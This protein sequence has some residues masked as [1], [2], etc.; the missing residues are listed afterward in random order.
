VRHR[1]LL[2]LGSLFVL[3]ASF[4]LATS[5]IDAQARPDRVDATSLM[6]AMPTAGAEAARLDAIM[7]G[8]G[9]PAVARAAAPIAP[10]AAAQRN[11]PEAQPLADYAFYPP[12]GA[13][14]DRPLRLLV[15]LHGMGGNGPEM[16]AALLP[17]A[18]AQGW[19]V[20]APTM[21]YRDFRDPELVRRD[22]ELLPR[23]KATLDA[24]PARTGLAFEPRV[25]LFGFSR[26][27]Q[28]SIR[29]SLMYPDA[30]LGVAGLSAG[31]YTLP[32]TTYKAQGGEQ[33]QVLR[34]PFGTG[35]VQ[36]ICG[37]SF[38]ADAVRRVSYWI[39]VGAK[40]NRVEDVPRQW[41]QFVGNNR[42]ERAR[43]YVEA[44]QQFGA[45]ATFH[46]FQNAD[47]EVTERMR[48]EAFAFLAALPA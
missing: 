40:D 11:V 15:V 26:G 21:P 4:G 41:D 9:D 28:E 37:R 17:V 12:P 7:R 36:A 8:A 30:V 27:S 42:V 3:V 47:H 18:H 44:L 2:A 14:A 10:T 43:R 38:D 31:S 46:L 23:L 48:Q 35:D 34:Y 6:A 13:T 24:L 33:A 29:F 22:G 20:L 19:A 39:G 5:P 1:L 16:A 32:S 45:P 25:S